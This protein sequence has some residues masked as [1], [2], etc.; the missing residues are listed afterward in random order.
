MSL[1]SGVSLYYLLSE[2]FTMSQSH[3]FKKWGR[4]NPL[5]VAEPGVEDFEIPYESQKVQLYFPM[6]GSAGV[7]KK[8]FPMSGE[9]TNG[10]IFFY[11]DC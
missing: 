4:E 3:H 6:K 11:Y 7:V 5:R 2:N 10:E 9:A 8:N 1:K